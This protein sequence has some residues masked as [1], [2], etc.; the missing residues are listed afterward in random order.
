MFVLQ[1][2]PLGLLLKATFLMVP[3]FL[4]T[5]RHDH[6]FIVLASF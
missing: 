1:R 5:L 6:V 3:L 2:P 4:L